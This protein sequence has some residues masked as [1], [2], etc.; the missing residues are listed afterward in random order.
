MARRKERR[1]ERVALG[2]KTMDRGA[3]SRLV[4][5]DYKEAPGGSSEASVG[6]RILPWISM[7]GAKKRKSSPCGSRETR[8]GERRLERYSLECPSITH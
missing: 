1:G 4:N 5:Y 7:G 6:L 8:L 2:V 3:V